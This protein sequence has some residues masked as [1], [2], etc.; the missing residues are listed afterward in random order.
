MPQGRR[1]DVGAIPRALRPA[2]ASGP[3]P[4]GSSTKRPSVVARCPHQGVATP[5]MAGITD[6]AWSPT[7]PDGDAIARVWNDAP[8]VMSGLARPNGEGLMLSGVY[9]ALRT[10][11]NNAPPA[12]R[13]RWWQTIRTGT[14]AAPGVQPYPWM[15]ALA[16]GRWR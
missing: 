13:L 14:A 10:P 5:A 12:P 1:G 7:T 11:A 4:C 9:A 8:C 2:A 16:G 6:V 3:S 15:M